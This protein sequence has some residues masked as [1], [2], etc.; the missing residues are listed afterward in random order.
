M[1]GLGDVRLDLLSSKGVKPPSKCLLC[2]LFLV[3]RDIFGGLT[4]LGRES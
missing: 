4:V 3:G 1:K 2:D